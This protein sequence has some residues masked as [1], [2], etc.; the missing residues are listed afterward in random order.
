MVPHQ[1]TSGLG[2]DV[3][4][5]CL[6]RSCPRWWMQRRWLSWI[7]QLC[8][9]S[10]RWVIWIH[11]HHEDYSCVDA[12]IHNDSTLRQ[13]ASSP[14]FETKDWV[15]RVET[16]RITSHSEASQPAILALCPCS[17][18]IASWFVIQDVGTLMKLWIHPYDQLIQDNTRMYP[19]IPFIFGHPVRRL[20]QLVLQKE[21]NCTVP[22]KA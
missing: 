3:K 22:C 1:A 21:P 2:L 6:M 4:R 17:W 5:Y 16:K 20:L 12:M 14:I 8:W 19:E 18:S 11:I 15:S 13:F 10:I 7:H 9:C